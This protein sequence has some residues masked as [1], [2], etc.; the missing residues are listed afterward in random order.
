MTHSVGRS[1]AV[2][3]S[4]ALFFFYIFIQMNFFNAI[5]PALFKKFSMD[6][7]QMAQL[8]QMYFYGNVLFLFPAGI[9]LDRF[10]TRRILLIVMSVSVVA[11]AA[12]AFSQVLI[13]ADIARFVLGVAG[14]FGLLAPVRL[15]TRW[16]PPQRMALVIGV[17]VTMAMVGGM[18]AQTPFV[19]MMQHFGYSK[20]LFLDLAIGVLAI[21]FIYVVVKDV[22]A[23]DKNEDEL[24]HHQLSDMGLMASVVKVLTLP[25]NW[26][27]GLYASLVNLPIFLFGGF[28][29]VLYLVQ[30]HHLTRYAASVVNG[31]IFFGMII[32]APL[33]GAWSDKIKR[34][35]MPM[36]IGAVACLLV[37]LAIM[38]LPHLGVTAL[39]VL[40]FLLGVVISCQVLSYP[41]VAESNLLSL[42][43]TAEGVASFL[44]MSGGFT[45]S[46]FAYL[47]NLDW[48][49]KMAGDVPVYSALSYE[50]GLSLML[51]AFVLALVLSFFIRETHCKNYDEA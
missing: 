16:F 27:A 26:C 42:T 46:L 39:A 20:T 21:F 6:A 22:P 37:F 30:M 25:Q 40:F 11:T 3:L 34:R 23:E 29:G 41:V 51:V 36:V 8:L 31:M 7:A 9:M 17:I 32:G 49:H 45:I 12:F 10:S 50:H 38:L 1:W 48:S 47:L 35:K 28:W 18:I 2:C 44:I 24:Q 14:A 19:L 33:F 13:E 4:A 43:G 5:E 15:A